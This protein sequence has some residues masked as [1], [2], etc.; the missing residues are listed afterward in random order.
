MKGK[1]MLVLC[2]G[3]ALALSIGTTAAVLS[4]QTNKADNTILFGNADIEILETF[5]GWETKEVRLQAAQGAGYVPGIARAK[6]V[7]YVTD[8]SGNYVFANLGPAQAPQ[9]NTLVFGD[10]TLVLADNWTDNWFYQ[11]GFFYC[12]TVLDPGG[13]T[14]LLLK[15]VTFT[16]ETVK[17]D[18]NNKQISIE[19]LADILQVSGTQSQ[20]LWGVAAGTNGAVAPV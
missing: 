9:G 19:V 10:I 1:G 18:Y 2:I 8:I 4:Y 17:E 6:L 13:T 11:D 7:P 3:I 20:T 5:D 16:N 14:A 12:K 15:K